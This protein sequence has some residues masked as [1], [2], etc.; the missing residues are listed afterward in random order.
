MR[1]IALT[2]SHDSHSSR[3]HIRERRHILVLLNNGL[4][5]CRVDQREELQDIVRKVCRWVS[6]VHKDVALVCVG[7]REEHFLP[8]GQHTELCLGS[9][10]PRTPLTRL[11][12]SVTVGRSMMNEP[13][14]T[15]TN[16]KVP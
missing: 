13:S 5:G 4:R 3:R 11:L 16:T 14:M 6:R 15:G 10:E 1:H 8:M 7:H 2:L 12:S 9:V